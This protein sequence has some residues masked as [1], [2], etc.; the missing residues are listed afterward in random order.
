VPEQVV[1]ELRE[2]TNELS[3]VVDRA[4]QLW[5]DLKET[6]SND[7]ELDDDLS[8]S[9]RNTSTDPVAVGMAAHRRF[10]WV[11]NAEGRCNTLGAMMQRWA[12]AVAAQLPSRRCCSNPCCVVLREMSE[13]NLVSGKACC[14]GNC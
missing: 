11:L 4:E 8:E 2:R 5:V 12:D 6:N 10:R 7:S 13:S 1:H 9:G 3:E 14:C